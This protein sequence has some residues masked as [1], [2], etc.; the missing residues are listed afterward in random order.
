VLLFGL[1]DAKADQLDLF[2]PAIPYQSDK[3][4]QAIDAINAKLG[5]DRVRL[6][7]QGLEQSWRMKRQL[8]SPRYTTQWQELPQAK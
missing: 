8:L 3:L 1:A 4:Y 2:A 5:R 7:V 6:F